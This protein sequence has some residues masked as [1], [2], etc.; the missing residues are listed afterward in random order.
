MSASARDRERLEGGPRHRPHRESPVDLRLPQ[1][2]DE[3]TIG[4][5][6]VSA[7]SLDSHGVAAHERHVGHPR[8]DVEI[9]LVVDPGEEKP[10]RF[11]S[12]DRRSAIGIHGCR[13][14]ATLTPAERGRRQVQG[15]QEDRNA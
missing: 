2:H 11:K 5:G 12:H 15:R 7:L 1:V 9:T 10:L 14:A 4:T 6:V 8:L 3:K 13:C